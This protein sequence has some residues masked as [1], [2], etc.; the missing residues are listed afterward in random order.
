MT[1]NATQFHPGDRVRYRQDTAALLSWRLA[2]PYV[3]GGRVVV[4]AHGPGPH[5]VLIRT[6]RGQLVVVVRRCL[7]LTGDYRQRELFA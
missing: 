4:A 5:N 2:D 1:G 3:T 6:D 7:T